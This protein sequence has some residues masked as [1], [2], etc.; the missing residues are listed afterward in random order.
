[1]DVG[2]NKSFK[3]VVLYE[4]NLCH[5]NRGDNDW[6]KL[7]RTDVAKWIITTWSQIKTLLIRKNWQQIGWNSNPDMKAVDLYLN[8][9]AEKFMQLL[10]EDSGDEDNHD[11]NK[12]TKN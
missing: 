12:M 6:A 4:Y 1:M 7:L 2:I 11:N 5:S 10:A 9:F 3:K 8:E